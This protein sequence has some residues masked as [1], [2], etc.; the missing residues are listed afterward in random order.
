V[1]TIRRALPL[2]L[3]VTLALFGPLADAATAGGSGAHRPIAVIAAQTSSNWGGYNQGILEAGKSGGFHQVSATWVVTTATQHQSG[4]S[5]NSATWVGVGGGCME[6][7]CAATDSTL[8][9]AG[10]S[11][12]VAANGTATY[13]VW[14][15]LIPAPSITITSLTVHA[16]DTVSVD[17]REAVNNSNVWTITVK[18]NS[19]TFTTTVPY[20][21][22]H[23][24]AEWIVETPIVIGTNGTGVAAM[25][26]L[27]KTQFTNVKTNSV[28][29]GLTAPEQI[30]LESNGQRLATPSAA[31]GTSF[32]VCTYTT[33]CS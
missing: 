28:S 32:S 12:D 19:A 14:Y 10:S 11:Q 15:E 8:I 9:Q 27:A 23:G 21:S 3:L 24:T 29:P 5:E 1:T 31:S 18:V 6:T 25:P 17:I 2:G 22:T 33:S 7:S 4:R 13:N 30:N 16:G 26:N 20:S